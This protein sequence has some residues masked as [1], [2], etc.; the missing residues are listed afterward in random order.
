MRALI[1]PPGVGGIKAPVPAE[2]PLR[3]TGPG[4]YEAW[5]DAPQIGTYLVNVLQK[6]TEPGKPDKATSLGL[7]TSYSPEYKDTQSNQYLMTQ[8]AQVG[9]GRVEPAPPSVF[10]VDRPAVF[11]A[12]DMIPWLLALPCRSSFSTSPRAALPLNAVT[13]S[14]P[15]PG[16][17][18]ASRRRRQAAPPRPNCHG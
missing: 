10:G 5:F 14:A 8:L 11:A 17:R 4:H 6:S 12:V 1:A 18:A 3:Q 2:Q 15:W 13:S 9:G 7:S 16:S